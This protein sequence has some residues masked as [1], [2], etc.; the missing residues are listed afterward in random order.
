MREHTRKYW[1]I[2]GKTRGNTK[3]TYDD[4]LRKIVGNAE[5]HIRKYGFSFSMLLA[6]VDEMGI[7]HHVERLTV[8]VAVQQRLTQFNH[9][10]LIFTSWPLK[11]S[12]FKPNVTLLM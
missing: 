7:C 12:V 1:D 4:I 3:G 5:E 8:I 9:H 11:S 10:I 6:K 2:L